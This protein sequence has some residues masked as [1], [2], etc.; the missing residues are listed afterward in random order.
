MS[1]APKKVGNTG[2]VGC[3]FCNPEINKRLEHQTFLRKEMARL[4]KM[5]IQEIVSDDGSPSNTLKFQLVTGLKI[6]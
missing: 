5:T 4:K 3:S 1:P 2:C 6:F